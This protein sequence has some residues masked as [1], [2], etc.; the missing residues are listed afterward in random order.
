MKRTITVYVDGKPQQRRYVVDHSEIRDMG[1][2]PPM[3][4]LIPEVAD[5]E[6]YAEMVDG[7][8]HIFK[9]CGRLKR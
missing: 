3:P 1:F 2:P 4:K 8:I 6:M 7:S 9:T 5:D